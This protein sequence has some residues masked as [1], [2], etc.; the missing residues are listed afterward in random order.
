MGQTSKAFSSGKIPPTH[1]LKKTFPRDLANK[2]HK[3]YSNY[4][5]SFN[6]VEDVPARCRGAGLD[7]L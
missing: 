4:S 6:I 3:L 1:A 7:D 5:L 2:I